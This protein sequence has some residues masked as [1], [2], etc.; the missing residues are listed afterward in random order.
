VIIDAAARSFVVAAGKA[1]SVM[2]E[3]AASR[4]IYI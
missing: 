4:Y 2:E 3:E 1:A